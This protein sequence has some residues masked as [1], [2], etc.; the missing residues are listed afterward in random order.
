MVAYLAA[1]L[2][3]VKVEMSAV[4]M[5]VEMVASSVLGLVELSVGYLDDG[6]VAPM[7]GRSDA[8]SADYSDGQMAALRAVSM[9]VKSAVD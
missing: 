3:V 7:V 1:L 9:A 4:G 6:S 2:G 5:V 8:Y